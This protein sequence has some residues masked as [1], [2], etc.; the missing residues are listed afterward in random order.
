[1][2]NYIS[3]KSTLCAAALGA[4]FLALLTG[5]QDEEFGYTAEQ[6]KYAK[7]YESFFGKLPAD[8]SWDL[9]SYTN[10]YRY[11]EESSNVTRANSVT[12]T[13]NQLQ[14]SE[15]GEYQ[16]KNDYWTVPHKTY[17]WMKAALK[18]GKDNRYLGSP[19]VLQ[20]P[21]NDFAI[22]PIFQ[23]KSSIMSELEVKINGYQITKVWTRSENIQVK[24][25]HAKNGITA[26][27]W[28]SIG[29]YDGYSGYDKS[30]MQSEYGHLSK[31]PSYTDEADDVRAKPIYFRAK[32][33]I[34]KSDKGFMYLSLHNI[35]K[36]WASW[37]NWNE[38]W[39]ENNEWTTIGHRLTSI[40]PQGHMLALNVP[41]Q[42]RPAPSELPD[43]CE[44]GTKPSQVIFVS[45]E[46]ANGTGT[47]HDVN[48]VAFL[49]IGYPNAPTIVPTTEIIE[50][51]YM[52]ED[53]GGTYDYDFNDIVIDCKQTQKYVVNAEPND[54][55]NYDGDVAGD[56]TIKDMVPDGC[57]VQTAKIAHLCGTI[58]LQ[59][60]IGSFM[61]PKIR[62]PR[63]NGDADGTNTD[64]KWS[65]RMDLMSDD[66]YLY[67][68]AHCS[69]CGNDHTN[70]SE[71][72]R[73]KYGHK[74]LTRNTTMGWDPN[75][76]QIIP[77]HTWNPDDN[78]IT[79]YADWGYYKEMY[80]A[81]SVTSEKEV[82]HNNPFPENTQ[83]FADFANGKKFPV[84]FPK[85]GEYPYII[86]TDQDVPW[87]NEGEHIPE[88]WVH[89]DMTARVDAGSKHDLIG[90]SFYMENYGHGDHWEGYIWSGDV[91]GLA[92]STGVTFAKPSAELNA[93][94][95]AFGTLNGGHGYYLLHVYAEVPAG[96]MAY[97]GLYDPQTWKPILDSDP[98]GYLVKP[99]E[100]RLHRTELGVDGLQCATIYLT[101]QQRDYILAHGLTIAS[102][103]DGV[104]IKKVT[105]ARPCLYSENSTG[106]SRDGGFII[107][108]DKEK[109][110]QGGWVL[111]DESVRQQDIIKEE[112]GKE[113]TSDEHAHNDA[114]KAR[115][116][117][118]F[119][120]H[121]FISGTTVTLT[122]IGAAIDE[123]HSYRVTGWTVSNTSDF[124]IS[125]T[126]S[127][128]LTI[129]CNNTVGWAAPKETTVY[130]NFVS[131]TNPK[132]KWEENPTEA[133]KT[134]TLAI[135]GAVTKPYKL[136]ATSNNL[137]PDSKLDQFGG[138][139][140]IVE[141]AFTIEDGKHVVSL[142]PK[143]VG[144]TTFT[145]Y[146]KDG[147]YN[148]TNYGVSGELKLTVKVVD[149]LPEANADLAKWMVFEWNGADADSYIIS[150]P[151]DDDIQI[152]LSS[153]VKTD[154]EHQIFGGTIWGHSRRYIDLPHANWLV[155][156]VNSGNVD[157]NFNK[158]V[159]ANPWEG[160]AITVNANSSYC[161]VIDNGTVG[162]KT[163]IID[164]KA[165][166][167]KYGYVHLVTIAAPW[168]ETANVEW[169]RVD[170]QYSDVRAE[171][172]DL[173][174]KSNPE[175]DK[176]T[177]DLLASDIYH[178]NGKDQS[179]T[180]A[181]QNG[182]VGT[183]AADAALAGGNPD[184]RPFTY[185][186]YKVPITTAG[187]NIYGHKDSYPDYFVDLS[188]A[189]VLVVT[190]NKENTN[191]IFFQFN[192]TGWGDNE[193]TRI[194]AK[195]RN[196]CCVKEDGSTITY[197]VDLDKIR[198]E[199][200]KT[201]Y[202]HL[203]A[204]TVSWGA[205]AKAQINS[206]KVDA[207]DSQAV[208]DFLSSSTKYEVHAICHLTNMAED[209][210]TFGYPTYKINSGSMFTKDGSG[211]YTLVTSGTINT[212]NKVYVT[213]GANITITAPTNDGYNFKWSNGSTEYSRTET[214]NSDFI[215]Y[216]DYSMTIAK[217]TELLAIDN[218]D[219]TDLDYTNYTI[220]NPDL[221]GIAGSN[222]YGDSNVGVDNYVDLSGYTVLKLALKANES[223]GNPRFVFNNKGNSNLFDIVEGKQNNEYL[224]VNHDLEG[225]NNVTLY[226]VNLKAIKETQTDVHL[227]C[228]KVEWNNQ[229]KVIVLYEKPKVQNKT[230]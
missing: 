110:L 3:R 193:V 52:C 115:A 35:D 94:D 125:N 43:I 166:R 150:K 112:N 34:G 53:L 20:L 138:N 224:H 203:N 12:P 205:N 10:H 121:Q 28:T 83:D 220:K 187:M 186:Y 143:V 14:N 72:E 180:V 21:D 188:A 119:T 84:E 151:S 68:H 13:G 107:K 131:A 82:K 71:G 200:T 174:G 159:A 80:T 55:E 65:S 223:T 59:V 26:S 185:V 195:D 134:I 198:N 157:F 192:K 196:Y 140:N 104:R 36:A 184:S 54:L 148:G 67:P 62:N 206:I 202:L 217:E 147:S 50:K 101:Q 133:S 106:S 86:A 97:I 168:Q 126:S 218:G 170:T 210:A 132:L 45:C 73:V 146:Q 109:V 204:I 5:C 165:L 37:T 142:T 33:K 124:T 122:A 30:T 175:M 85:T 144:E 64:G 98:D 129:T 181:D 11:G 41:S 57:P 219:W 38:R 227:N 230:L 56:I 137:S 116:S 76:E 171:W 130:P 81:T 2:N 48:D 49:I 155:A 226:Y 213:A 160:D 208:T 74:N 189:T 18:E 135:N 201:N 58:P 211:N 6:I 105:T 23:G 167:Q 88:G 176:A 141:A 29:Y 229:D 123:D 47:D 7:A 1:M 178:W 27:D 103:T 221:T 158:K 212:V 207:K 66:Y 216:A 44:D 199:V 136:K 173:I 154:G 40:N 102:L 209:N 149:Q 214:I 169:I 22:I 63:N 156:E 127:N 95:E 177:I 117:V 179:A 51:R 108:I 42:Y 69:K 114:E 164:L 4:T 46:D 19:F 15:T 78:N 31:Y 111:S 222:G 190:L 61:F 9:S 87:M 120:V 93:M 8:K 163:Y 79:I 24:D 75:E 100:E 99:I 228:I 153:P 32:D 161:T 183:T 70:P 197:V 96:E 118:P 60:Q 145:I 17:D 25:S 182:T 128:P 139:T 77:C 89:G 215:T 162:K 172:D 16:V 113:L 225:S 91:T 92:G 191:S 152:N 90:N 194:S 39:D